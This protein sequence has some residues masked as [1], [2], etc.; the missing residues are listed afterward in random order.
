MMFRKYT[1]EKQAHITKKYILINFL[2]L[3]YLM[4]KAESFKGFG[5]LETYSMEKYTSLNISSSVS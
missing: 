5:L 3:R 2:I 1:W 4:F